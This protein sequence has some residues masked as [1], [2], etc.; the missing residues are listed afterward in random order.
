MKVILISNSRNSNSRNSSG[1]CLSF[2]YMKLILI[3]K[4]K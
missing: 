3:L 4:Y 1:S 2:L